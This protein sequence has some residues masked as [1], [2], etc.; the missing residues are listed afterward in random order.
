MRDLLIFDR[1]VQAAGSDK[2]RVGPGVGQHCG[3]VR[4][5]IEV[6]FSRFTLAALVRGLLAAKSAARAT[7]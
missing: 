4:Q 7:T 3:H 6:G 1:V 2:V 5:V